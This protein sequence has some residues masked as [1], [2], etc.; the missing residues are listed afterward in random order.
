[1]NRKRL[2]IL[3]LFVIAILWWYSNRKPNVP[4][5][6]Y[7]ANHPDMIAED[8]KPSDNRTDANTHAAP[9]TAA[10]F[11]ARQE[12]NF[13][14]LT[15]A[16]NEGKNEWRTPIEFFGK[17]VDENTNP[18]PD[19][20]IHFVWTN[21]SPE[22]SSETRTTSDTNGL[23][24]L[25]NVTG[26][27]LTVQVSKQGYYAYKSYPVGFFYAGE[28]E[29]FVP[30]ASN[31]VEFRLHK[32]G[33]AE[34]IIVFARNIQISISGKPLELDLKT[35]QAVPAGQGDLTVEFFRTPLDQAKRQVFD[36]S[37]KITPQN[38]GLVLSTR[39]F[40]FLAPEAGY[41]PSEL[42][43][44]PL[45]LGEKWQGR[46]NRQYFL[47]LADGNYARVHLDLRP[48]NGSLRIES[49]L[50]PSGSR[51]L[52]YDEAVQPKPTVHE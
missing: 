8:S 3:A 17:I 38:G 21:L 40:D 32:K 20:D 15:N 50:N 35:G 9:M 37:L 2:I 43:D 46:M 30:D 36:W 39:E 14:K 23:F 49:F 10:E 19:A 27:V 33:K 41:Q 12:E 22:G 16:I 47:K 28:N 51:N 42:I 11:T 13:R 52:E 18:V 24:V 48:S 34:P 25:G 6:T 7:D 1:M 31:P 44:M 26:K 4:T 45:S 29:N 5:P